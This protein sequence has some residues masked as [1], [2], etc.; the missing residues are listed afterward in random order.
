MIPFDLRSSAIRPFVFLAATSL[1]F[2][3]AQAASAQTQVQGTRV[4]TQVGAT[5]VGGTKVGNRTGLQDRNGNIYGGRGQ[6]MGDGNAFGGQTFLWAQHAGSGQSAGSGNLLDA[7]SQIGSGGVNSGSVPLNFE[8]RNLLVTGAVPGGRGFRGS[9]GY[10]PATDFRGATGSDDTYVFR[11]ASAF[12][13]PAF[14][15][16]EMAHD[17]FMLAQGLGAFEYRRATTPKDYNTLS[18]AADQPDSR[19]RLDR[20]NAQMSFGRLNWEL[21]ADRTI[22]TS[23]AAN[24]DGLRY[25]IS[26]LRGLQIENLTDPLARSGMSVYERAR[27]RQDI[28][29][30][31]ATM[32]DYSMVREG[33]SMQAPDSRRVDNRLKMKSEADRLRVDPSS[34]LPKSYLD[35]IDSI[36]KTKDGKPADGKTDGKPTD[37]KTDGKSPTDPS[38][39]SD[40]AQT[41]L[42]QVRDALEALRPKNSRPN[43]ETADPSKSDP[44]KPTTRPNSTRPN[45]TR[46]DPTK[47]ATGSVKTDA[48]ISPDGTPR[49]AEAEREAARVKKRGVILSVD[50][51]ALILRHGKTINALSRD[52]RRRVDELVMQGESA[53]RESD[54]FRAERRFEQAQSLASDNPLVEVGITHAQLGAGLYLSASLTLRNLFVAFP[55]LIDA[56][57]DRAL[58]PN[59]DR[60]ERAVGFMRERIKSGEDAPGYGILLA[61]IGHQT[62]DRKLV[63]EGLAVI[64]GNEKLDLS[65]K[66][67]EGVWLGTK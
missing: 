7:N 34:M 6:G 65:R 66:L 26:P 50:D 12:S 24:G 4:G 53:L 10:T 14:A 20:A 8:A 33:M 49:S 28:A 60:L 2:A 37:G 38:M 36:N 63:E 64:G 55:E 43:E 1:S 29:A 21:G 35:I 61:Y 46:P 57:Y 44:T 54:Y 32:A 25:V 16:S 5:M 39:P 13:S 11:A 17:R 27:A 31:I 59:Q 62:S 30:G 15:A 9:V 18:V 40:A 41:P 56:K 47:P 23:T 22:A 3:V 58:L 52:D 42:E 19:L 51:A 67:L 48:L 45:S